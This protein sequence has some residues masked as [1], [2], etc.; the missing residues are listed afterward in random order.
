MTTPT[1]FLL[2]LLGLFVYPFVFYPPVLALLARMFPFKRGDKRPFP[3]EPVALVICAL[4]EQNVIRQKIENSLVLDYPKDM[5]EIVVISDGSSDQT[6]AI[7]REYA[8]KGIRL[9]DQ[10]VRRGKVT[11]LS[12]VVPSLAQ[13]IIVFSDA[14]VMYDPQAI[15]NLVRRFEDPSVGAC[16]GGSC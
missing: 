7:V 12:E 14:N 11:N 8:G 10:P 3:T 6:A 9:I 15:N 16:R 13:N 4:N 1:I 2:M 5:L